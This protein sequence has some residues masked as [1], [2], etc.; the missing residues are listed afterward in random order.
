M[1][2]ATVTELSVQP[3]DL[4]R[5]RSNE[6]VSATGAFT[7]N[8]QVIALNKHAASLMVDVPALPAS[9][10]PAQRGQYLRRNTAITALVDLNRAGE[11][12]AVTELGWVYPLAKTGV[13]GSI[14]LN[15]GDRMVG[16]MEI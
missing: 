1:A 3:L 8:D 5:L 7:L 13:P 12:Y 6:W 14:K 2:R 9:G 11:T 16:T 15:K 10:P 4:L